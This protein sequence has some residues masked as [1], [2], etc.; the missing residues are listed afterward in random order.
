M[1]AP[2]NSPPTGLRATLAQRPRLS[3]GLQWAALIISVAVLT[4]TLRTAQ[5]PAAFLLGPLVI[6]IAF[7]IGGARTRLPGAVRAGGQALIGCIIAIALGATAGPALLGQVPLFA[8]TSIAT[9]ALSLA[10]GAGLTRAGWFDGATAVWGLAPGG[11]ASMVMLAEMNKADP[12]VTALM[13]YLRILFAAGSAIAVSHV[14]PGLAPTHAPG[15]NWFPPVTALGLAQSAFL[16]ILGVA[17]AKLT[18]FRPAIFLVPG[19]VGACL[20]AGGWLHPEVPP[21][22]AAPAY[23]VIGLNIGLSFTPETLRACARQLPRIVIA[24]LAL[25]ALCAASGALIGWIFHVD[26][27]TAYLAT[28][29]GGLDA[30]LIVATSTHADVSF[31]IAAQMFRLLVVLVAGPFAV[32]LVARAAIRR[33]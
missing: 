30:V 32:S 24:V 12:R 21:Y 23:A 1:D 15:T 17:A 16:V 3:L 13:Q 8:A 7:G 10:L 6:G 22:I 31:V 28:T 14:L 19:I 5:A 27:M 4:V 2:E 29:P 25:V 20:I 18:R 33:T 11:S 9:L 26:P